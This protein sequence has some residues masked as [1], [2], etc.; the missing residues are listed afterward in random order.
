MSFP[1]LGIG[2]FSVDPVAFTVPIFGGLEVRWYGLIITLGI[3]LAFLYCSFRAKQEGIVFDD[4]LDIALFTVI[5]AIIGA[6][7]YYVLTSLDQYHSLKEA[8]AIWNGGLAIYGAIIAG[9]ITIFIV[10]RVKKIN[11]VKMLDAVAPAVMIGQ[12]L[13][14]WGNFFNGEAYGAV[15]EEG[16]IFYFL[17][18]GLLP[19]IKSYSTMFY[20][21]P[22]FLYESVWNLVGFLIINALYKKKK[23]DGQV[24]LMY[25]TWYGFGRM[26]IE[27]LRTDSLYVGVFRISQIVGFLCFVIGGTLLIVNL[28]KAR[29]AVLDQADYRPTYEKLT[30]LRT[31]KPKKI[32]SEETT[33]SSTEQTD[34][35]EQ[36]E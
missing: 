20:F 19:N 25:I 21:H 14:R 15:V 10:C 24:V 36:K 18:M 4:L 29:R 9:A 13:G 11:V 12:I 17:R 6:R 2:T 22:T 5:F 7:L 26:L 8:I 27:G 35:K 1:G 28:L 31:T 16:N 32:S 3:V 34:S 30:R 33:E 23:F